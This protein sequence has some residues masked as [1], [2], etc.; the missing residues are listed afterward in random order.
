MKK[1][2]MS[3]VLAA[4]MVMGLAG[5]GGSGDNAAESTGA[6][7]KKTLTVAMECGYAG[8]RS[9]DREA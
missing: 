2:I 3:L 1:K 4:A 6:D 8:I 5:C 9:G 7:G